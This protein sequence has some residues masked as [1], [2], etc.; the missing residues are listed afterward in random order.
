MILRHLVE[1]VNVE[2]AIVLHFGVVEE[3]SLHPGARRRLAGFRA[4]F[5]DDA[6]D[7]HELHHVRIADQDLVEQ[8]VAGAHDCGSR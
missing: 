2:Q 3:I 6:G 8:Y 5:V 1:V 4:E 7:G